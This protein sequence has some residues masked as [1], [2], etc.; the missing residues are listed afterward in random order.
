LSRLGSLGDLVEVKNGYRTVA[1]ACG[2]TSPVDLAQ[3]AVHGVIERRPGGA[4]ERV[5]QA[6]R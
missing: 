5:G 2:L 4:P 1:D 6:H 3:Q